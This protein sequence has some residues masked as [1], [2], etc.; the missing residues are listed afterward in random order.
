[1]RSAVELLE[2]LKAE[3]PFFPYALPFDLIFFDRTDALM[4]EPH[5]LTSRG[6]IPWDPFNGGNQHRLNPITTSQSRLSS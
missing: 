5:R 4:C 6:H 3:Q 2:S 1:M